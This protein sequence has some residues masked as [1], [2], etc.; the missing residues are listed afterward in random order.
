[1]NDARALLA[2]GRIEEA[3]TAYARLLEVSPEHPEALHVL[4]VGALRNGDFQQAEHLLAR[5]VTLTPFDAS[6]RYHLGR[7]RELRGDLRNAAEDYTAACAADAAQRVARLH[8]GSILERLGEREQ[9]NLHYARALREAHEAGEWLDARTTPP[10]L[11]TLV[12]HASRCVRA[13]SRA[14][15][16]RLLAPLVAR[17]GRASL[18]RVERC[19]RIYLND[20]AA[21]RPDPRQQ[22]SFLYFPDLPTTPYFDRALFPWIDAFEA[23]TPRIRAE[24]AAV[25]QTERGSERVFSSEELEREN[26]R[27]ADA[28]PSWTGYYFYRHGMRRDDNCSACPATA[29]ALDTVTLCH[30]REHGPEVLFSVF[31]AGT[32]LLP[33]RGVTNTRLVAHLPLIVPSD[34]ALVVGGERY[35][36]REGEVVVFDDTYEHEAWNR[37]AQTRVVLIMDVW[38]PYLTEVE[39]SAVADLVAEIG[40]FRHSLEAL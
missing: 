36:W 1:L 10:A 33:H 28:K 16:D 29:A 3:E 39:R 22:P 13:S 31:T 24:L 32:H 40:D 38:N 21:V 30:V 5:A 9:G 14:M 7:V 15:F 11:A 35:V 12:E 4:G 18:A 34:C 17:Y 25:L 20:E 37:G 27:G 19:I 23:Q 6:L 2:A 26:L 8:L